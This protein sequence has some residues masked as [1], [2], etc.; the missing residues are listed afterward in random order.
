MLE[1]RAEMIDNQ[2]RISVFEGD[3]AAT[4]V[5]YSV[6]IE[7]AFDAQTR[8]FPMNL[9]DGLMNLATDDIVKGRV[10]LLKSN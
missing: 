1:T 9:L 2:V 10:P 3:Q 7:S 8:G 5:I 4:S 6:S